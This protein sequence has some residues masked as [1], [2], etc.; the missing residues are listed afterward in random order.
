[1]AMNV[2]ITNH[3]LSVGSLELTGVAA[4]SMLQIGDTDAITLYSIFDTPPEAVIIGPF[5]PLPE[6]QAAPEAGI[7]QSEGGQS[8]V[9]IAGTGETVQPEVTPGGPIPFG[10]NSF[11]NPTGPVN[12]VGG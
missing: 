11:L 12:V 4:A 7:I 9:P 2:N 10:A 1:M 3:V 5:A 8:V 6:P